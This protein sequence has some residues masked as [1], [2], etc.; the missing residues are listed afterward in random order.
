MASRELVTA[1]RTWYVN[2]ATG[3]DASDG[4][5]PALAF[6]TIQYAVNLLAT[7]IDFSANCTL[8]LANT[9]VVYAENVVLPRLVGNGYLTI[10]GDAA[11]NSAV[12]VVGPGAG[13][14]FQAVNSV[15]FMLDSLHIGSYGQYAVISDANSHLLAHN[16]NY[17]PAT[18]ASI[19][20]EHMGFYEDLAGSYTVSSANTPWHIGV[21]AGGHYVDQGNYC[22]FTGNPSFTASFALV[23]IGGF[24]DCR[25]LLGWSGA[26]TSA[27]LHNVNNDGTAANVALKPNVGYW[28]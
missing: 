19:F 4:S 2:N 10:Q 23:A 6:A 27:N 22:Y 5:T 8:Q 16:M 24:L 28:P 7:T 3:S 13:P 14:A 18:A 21:A 9:G 15:G 26:Y 12:V 25:L 20:V 17:G 1:A 11:D